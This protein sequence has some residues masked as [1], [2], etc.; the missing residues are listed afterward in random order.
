MIIRRITRVS[1]AAALAV[2]IAGCE[3]VDNKA[4]SKQDT[5]ASSRIVP[6]S[7][8]GTVVPDS[9]AAQVV[10]TDTATAA[11]TPDDTGVVRLYPP[12]ARRGGVLFAL[13]EGV[14]AASPRCSWKSAPIPCYTTGEG[15]VVTIPLPAD[16]DAGTFM[17]TFD[18]PNGKI[19]R[20]IA[21]ADREF[22][23]ELILLTD[24]LYKRATSSKEIA[25]DARA[26]RGMAS[27]ESAERRW[28]GRWREPV[29]GMKS[30]GYGVERYYYR[31]TDSTRSIQ[32]DSQAKT[33]ATFGGD[34]TDVAFTGAPSWR[35]AGIDLPARRGASVTAPASGVVI[36]VGDYVLS[37]RTLLVDHGQGVVSAYFH[38]DTA[39]VS[40]GDVVRVGERI[41][42][43]GSTGLAT[44]PH[45][46]YGIYLHGKD[47]D[48]VA[49]RDMPQW[50]IAQGDSLTKK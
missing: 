4:A 42:R 32:L 27:M 25:R 48:P 40:K 26:V 3:V 18:R 28:T 44:G 31:A 23:R 45:L 22:P 29:T 41:A 20:Q 30:T 1:T 39:L 19:V 43:V 34:T 36:D 5:T 24:S 6:D 8:A 38:L 15:T 14:T 17:L 35:H 12:E 2:L 46:H 16:D 21:V 11:P 50:L 7:A 37:G 13:A 49:W 10:P 33:R 47:V 9:T